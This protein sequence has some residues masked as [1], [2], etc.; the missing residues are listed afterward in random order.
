MARTW[1]ERFSLSAFADE[2][3]E[4]FYR[5]RRRR[6]FSRPLIFV[7]VVVAAVVVDEAVCPHP[8]IRRTPAISRT[9]ASIKQMMPST[10]TA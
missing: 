2:E 3:Q 7:V 4:E 6:G 8:V 10:T 5:A 9:S 1:R